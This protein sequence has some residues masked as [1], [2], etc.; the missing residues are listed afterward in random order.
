MASVETLVLDEVDSLLQLGFE[1]QVREIE[2]R[3][4]GVRQKLFFSATI[5]PRIER[6]ASEML[7]DHLSIC[8][9][10]VSMKENWQSQ[11]TSLQESGV[12]LVEY[13]ILFIQ[14][15][16]PSKAVQHT[17]I[18]VEENG[19]KKTLFALLEDKALLKSVHLCAY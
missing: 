14:P 18:W 13:L 17:V 3:L 19:K 6:I 5:P 7:E 4:P 8:V 10:Q 1:Q 16:T 15:C 2:E 9:G 11:F 12:C